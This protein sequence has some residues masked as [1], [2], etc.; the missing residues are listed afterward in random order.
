MWTF[1]CVVDDDDDSSIT[2]HSATARYTSELVYPRFLGSTL[3][4]QEVSYRLLSQND[5]DSIILCTT[6][7]CLNKATYNK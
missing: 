5:D 1:H 3:T 7:W 6:C 2:E 4:N